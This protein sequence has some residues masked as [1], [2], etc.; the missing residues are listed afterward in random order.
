M[1]EKIKDIMSISQKKYVSCIFNIDNKNTEKLLESINYCYFENNHFTLKYILYNIL[2][3]SN[4]NNLTDEQVFLILKTIT[5]IFH[6]FEKDVDSEFTEE[7]LESF[8]ENVMLEIIYFL[9]ISYLILRYI[10]DNFNLK[11]FSTDIINTVLSG[12]FMEYDYIAISN[13]VDPLCKTCYKYNTKFSKKVKNKFKQFGIKTNKYS[14]RKGVFYFSE[15]TNFAKLKL[16]FSSDM[17]FID[18]ENIYKKFNK[19]IH[20]N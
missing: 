7:V 12:K 16:A 11:Y 18:M 2:E 13:T 5:L 3:I 17:Y 14:T 19:L 4:K 20:N 6:D 1:N 9:M 8:E 15:K 10:N